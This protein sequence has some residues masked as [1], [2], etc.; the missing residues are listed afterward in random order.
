[1]WITHVIGPGYDTVHSDI[2]ISYAST[3]INGDGRADVITDAGEAPD[4]LPLP[5]GGLIWWEAPL[6]R[7]NGTWIKHTIDSNIVYSH[8]LRLGDFNNDGTTDISFAEQDQSPQK[9]VGILFNVGGTGQNWQM[10]VLGTGGGHNQW[11]AD[12]D[13]DGDLDILS[14]P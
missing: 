7:K 4:P 10:Q 5:P 3:D 9:R 14:S 6:D 8:N 13:G 12:D 11:V 2:G 1:T